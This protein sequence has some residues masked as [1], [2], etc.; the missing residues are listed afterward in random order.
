MSSTV[1]YFLQGDK[2][3][4]VEFKNAWLG[5]M[6]IW[7]DVA[8]RHLGLS[9][10]PFMSSGRSK[11][12]NYGNSHPEMPEH[13]RIVLISTMDGALAS[14]SQLERLVAA[15]EKYG[16][17]HPRSS[18]AAQAKEIKAFMDSGEA[19]LVKAIGWNQNS[20][21][22]D[23]WSSYDEAS[24]DYVSYDPSSGSNHFWIVEA[25]DESFANP[26]KED[27]DENNEQR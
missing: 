8:M 11:V 2:Q 20:I 4:D 26:L 12:W 10:F 18:V 19:S 15:F 24:D 13:E 23:R 9:N 6:Y 27:E 17:E 1:M 21:C 7:N 25:V 14:I 3:S 22:D 5:A 16:E